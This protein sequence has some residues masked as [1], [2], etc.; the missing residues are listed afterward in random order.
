M[1][2]QSLHTN[3]SIVFQ[4]ALLAIDGTKGTSIETKRALHTAQKTTGSLFGG[5]LVARQVA[6][7]KVQ[8]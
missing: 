8:L 6:A 2:S 3:G 1:T 4:G 5:D 7:L